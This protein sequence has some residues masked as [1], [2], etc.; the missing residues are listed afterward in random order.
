MKKTILPITVL[1][2]TMNRPQTLKRTLNK[3]LDSE[4]LPA[5]IVVVD[6]ST[7]EEIAAEIKRLVEEIRGI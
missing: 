6:Q 4:C 5:Q 3:Y 1:I 7:S 2:P